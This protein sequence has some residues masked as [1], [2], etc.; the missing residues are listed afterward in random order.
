MRRSY[1]SA[2]NLSSPCSGPS[3]ATTTHRFNLARTAKE[4]LKLEQVFLTHSPVEQLDL[5][6]NNDINNN[7]DHHRRRTHNSA[8]KDSGGRCSYLAGANICA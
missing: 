5:R 3:F 6:H 2:H 8:S 1:D 4:E 7:N